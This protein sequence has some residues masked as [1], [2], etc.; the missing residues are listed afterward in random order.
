M[1]QAQAVIRICQEQ[2]HAKFLVRQA[3]DKKEEKTKQKAKKAKLLKQL[4][5]L[6]AAAERGGG[7]RSCVCGGRGR[8]VED[9]P[10]GSRGILGAVCLTPPC[11]VADHLPI[12]R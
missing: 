3:A 10:C 12:A 1:E 11:V 9:P 7:G 4:E 8:G 2:E 5:A 6:Q